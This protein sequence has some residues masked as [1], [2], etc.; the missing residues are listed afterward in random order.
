MK[1]PMVRTQMGRSASLRLAAIFALA[2]LLGMVPWHTTASAQVAPSLGTAESFAV[3]A[4]STVISTGPT[5]IIGDMGTGDAFR[6]GPF[7]MR[8]WRVDPPE[9]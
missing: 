2:V 7:G 6:T 9:P 8:W 1:D 5:A 3:L 4:G